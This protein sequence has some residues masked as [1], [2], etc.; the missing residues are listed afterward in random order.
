MNLS[1]AVSVIIPTRNRAK[2]LRRAVLSVLGQS[3][4]DLELIVIDDGSTDE[5]VQILETIT[6]PRLRVIRRPD[7]GGAS[8][9]RNRGIAEARGEYIAFQDDDDIWLPTKL[10][11]QLQL[12]QAAGA[13]SDACLCA[14]IAN[15]GTHAEYVGGERA[16][17]KLDFRNG[18]LCHTGIVA[19]PG[20]LVRKEVFARSGVFDPR[21]RSFEDWELL[22]RIS[23]Q[24]NLSFTNEAL[25]IQ[26]RCEG[27]GLWNL[28]EA[29]A[30]SHHVI[31]EKHADS[32]RS[33]PQVLANYYRWTGRFEALY[34]DLRAARKML[35]LAVATD[36][37]QWR[38]WALLLLVQLGRPA[39]RMVLERRLRR[40]SRP[41]VTR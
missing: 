30:E 37:M 4:A 3:H 9:A 26:D 12:L 22:Y 10:E 28:Y 19:T 15:H 38:A 5:T 23:Q 33:Q 13:D 27:G 7:G 41:P 14:Y 36:R 34:G 32:W 11:S 29:Y 24:T 31:V 40:L 39:V 1:P 16:L 21:L 25:F 35:R 8:S 20:W 17:D 2:L 18:P 6:D